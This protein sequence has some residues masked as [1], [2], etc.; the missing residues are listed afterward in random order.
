MNIDKDIA[1]I[2]QWR[3]SSEKTTKIGILQGSAVTQNALGRLVIGLYHLF[4]I[5]CSVCLPKI[6]KIGWYYVN[7]IISEDKLGPLWT[8]WRNWAQ[9]NERIFDMV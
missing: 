9:K 8:Q 7:I 6:M 5:F 2:K 1:K 3:F 4:A